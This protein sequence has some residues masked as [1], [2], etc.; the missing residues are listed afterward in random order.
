MMILERD[1]SL[2]E[3]APMQTHGRICGAWLKQ[4][5]RRTGWADLRAI[6]DLLRKGVLHAA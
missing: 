6:F 1:G 2:R 3:N 5:A 4:L